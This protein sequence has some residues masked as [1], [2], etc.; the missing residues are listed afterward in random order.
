MKIYG[1]I[2][3]PLTHSF[4]Q[5]YFNEK[6]KREKINAEYLNFAISNIDEFPELV[7]QNPMLS[8][9]N[10]TIPYKE[11][12]FSFLDDVDVEAEKIK[13]VNVIKIIEKSPKKLYLK[14]YNSDVTGFL[15][16]LTP[17][18]HARHTKALILGTGGASKAIAHGLT[19]LG[20][21][22]IFVSR[23]PKT[24]MQI[25]YDKINPSIISDYKLIINT[26]PL[27]MHPNVNQFPALPYE[28]MSKQHLAYDLI[29]N[30][31]QTLF[32]KNAAKFGA[33][34]KNGLE[35]LYLQAE[36]AWRIWK[37]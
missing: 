5:P 18:L 17:L 30:P 2:G 1:L 22:F 16:S 32:L 8:G 34:T 6:F 13:A 12:I 11:Q 14:G 29:Y 9:L 25:S 3:Y 36:E 31:E 27:G 7:Q 37:S 28:A 33:K 4:S 26:T 23:N 19:K 15:N 35:M 21:P 10:V 24:P 20:I